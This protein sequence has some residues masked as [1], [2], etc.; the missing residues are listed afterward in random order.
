L[1]FLVTG[2]LQAV[3]E[4]NHLAGR[5]VDEAYIRRI[6]ASTGE[7]RNRHS[8]V[9][10]I[11]DYIH[12]LLVRGGIF[13]RRVPYPGHLLARKP[14]LVL[15]MESDNGAALR[16]H[17]VLLSDTDGEAESR[18]L[19]HDLIGSVDRLGA[20]NFGNRFHLFDGSEQLHPNRCGL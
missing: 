19:C 13:E 6:Q 9:S 10:S 8:C 1:K 16:A 12:S 5:R 11:G 3:D 20:T 18:G 15:R 14:L 4:D 17:Q 2:P 7:R